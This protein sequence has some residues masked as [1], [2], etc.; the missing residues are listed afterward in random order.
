MGDALVSGRE[1]IEVGVVQGTVFSVLL[2][3]ASERHP[4]THCGLDEVGVALFSGRE[5]VEVWLVQETVSSGWLFRASQRHSFVVAKFWSSRGQ[6]VVKSWS[7]R[8]QV[9]V[10]GPSP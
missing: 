8:G 9:V 4:S 1:W 2:F 3:R 5:L 6:V 7:S 10:K